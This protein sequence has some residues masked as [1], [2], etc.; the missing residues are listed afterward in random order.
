MAREVFGHVGGGTW[1]AIPLRSSGSRVPLFLVH[2]ADGDVLAF[3]MLARRLGP[4]QPTYGLRARGIDDGMPPHSTMAEMATD[5][6]AAIRNVQPH[7]PYVLGGYCMGGPVALEMA[8]QLDDAGDEVA[9]LVLLD[10][11]FRRPD[12]LR[13]R[14]WRARRRLRLARHRAERD[15]GLAWRRA[16]ERQLVQTFNRRLRSALSKP[17]ENPEIAKAL[18]RMREDY[19]AS[20]FDFPTT[21]VVSDQFCREVLPPWQI[22]AMVERPDRWVRLAG[23]HGRL[24]LPPNVDVVAAEIRAALDEAVASPAAALSGGSA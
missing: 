22:E 7:G 24:L 1:G 14:G 13:Y 23:P 20:P 3:A 18:A 8:R 5:Y 2:P 17:S 16:R 9:M 10:P 12:G 15:V 4:D 21:V 19:R 6:V 11:R